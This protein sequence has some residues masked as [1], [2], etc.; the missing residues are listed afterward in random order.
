MGALFISSL[1]VIRSMT[2]HLSSPTNLDPF[3]IDLPSRRHTTLCAQVYFII[4]VLNEE[5]NF[6]N[7][8][9]HSILHFTDFEVDGSPLV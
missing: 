2:Y 3:H 7:F 4:V 5:N 1:K 9:E 6:S 8:C